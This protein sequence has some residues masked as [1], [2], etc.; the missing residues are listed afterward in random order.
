MPVPQIPGW[1]I[2]RRN[3]ESL[4]D[5]AFAAGAALKCLDDLSVR[6]PVWAGCWRN[7]QALRCAAAAVRLAGRREDE[8][9]LRDAVLLTP[10]DGD[11]GPAGAMVSGFAGLSARDSGIGAA[12]VRNLAVALGLPSPQL[13]DAAIDLL[14]DALQSASA[15][16]IAAAE[17]VRRCYE[18]HPEAEALAFGLADLVIANRLNWTHPVPLMM[19]ARYGAAFRSG[20]GRGRIMPGDTGFAAAVA[21]AVVES[22]DMALRLAS[23]VARGADRLLAARRQVRTKGADRIYA[24][25]L[26]QDAVPATVP[27]SGLSRWASMRMFQRLEAL[28][29]VRELSGRSSFR[30]YGI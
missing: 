14:D 2:S 10:P 4:A 3:R 27:A 21:M 5:A 25:L 30:I 22:A 26:G 29:A 17:L 20:Q 19:T 28:G 23:T 13:I 12:R 24:M 8:A 15:P 7:R 11:P 1:A 18:N 6:A 16:P 9:M